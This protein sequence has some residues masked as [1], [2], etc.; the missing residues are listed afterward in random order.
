MTGPADDRAKDLAKVIPQPR[1][2]L[3]GSRRQYLAAFDGLV[4]TADASCAC[5]TPTAR[6]SS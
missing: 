3:I 2:E 4:A 5:S 6:S 1:R